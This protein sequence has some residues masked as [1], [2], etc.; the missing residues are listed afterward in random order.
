M[1][2]K[3]KPLTNQTLLKATRHLAARDPHLAQIF[4]KFGVPPMWER[5]EGFHTLLHI[6]LEQQVSLASAK[7]AYDKLVAATRP[8]TPKHFIRAGR[9][10]TQSHRL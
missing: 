1:V 4:S 7:A 6:I 2:S 5:E 8:L 3:P 9:R 10:P